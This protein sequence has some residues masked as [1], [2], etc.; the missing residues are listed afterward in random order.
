MDSS[1]TEFSGEGKK[2]PI[3]V[4][5]SKRYSYAPNW[6]VRARLRPPAQ[7]GQVTPP[8]AKITVMGADEKAAGS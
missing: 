7:I 2:L 3:P 1:S 4:S 8:A 6:R 5:R